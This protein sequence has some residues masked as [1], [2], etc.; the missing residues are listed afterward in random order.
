M[1]IGVLNCIE[2]GGQFG[3]TEAVN[4]LLWVTNNDERHRGNTCVLLDERRAKDFPLH[5][6]GVLKLIN[7]NKPKPRTKLCDDRRTSNFIT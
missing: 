6:V 7:E 3:S 4:R 2:I 1:L 5:G